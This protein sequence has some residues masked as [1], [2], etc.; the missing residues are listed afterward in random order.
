MLKWS[1]VCSDDQRRRLAVHARIEVDVLE[2]VD[3]VGDVAE[4]H[5][6]AVG[7]LAND[8]VLEVERGVGEIARLQLEVA[9]ARCA[10]RRRRD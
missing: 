7:R 4:A 9:V 6:A 8:D 10:P 3:D 1:A 2:A 5:D